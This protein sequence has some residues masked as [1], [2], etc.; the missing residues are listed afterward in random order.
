MI[1]KYLHG[2]HSFHFVSLSMSL[3]S[4]GR[5]IC[6]LKEIIPPHS[7]TECDFSSSTDG[8]S[9][10]NI[11]HLMCRSHKTH[12]IHQFY[13]SSTFYGTSPLDKEVLSPKCY[14]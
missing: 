11:L 3:K 8:G 10:A 4:L 2:L 7:C 9:S 6:V 1:G 5:D 13:G 14:Q 12:E